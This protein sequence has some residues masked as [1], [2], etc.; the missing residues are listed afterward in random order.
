MTAFDPATIQV[1]ISQCLLGEPVRYDGGH[2]HSTFCTGVL[3][4]YFAFQPVCPEMGAG[5]GTPRESIRLV[6]EAH[7]PRLINSRSQTDV[8]DAIDAYIEVTLPKLSHL[9]GFILMRKSPSCGM[10]RVKVYTTQG[11]PQAQTGQG[12]FAQALMQAYPLL[13]IEEEGRLNDPGLRE[14]FINRVLIWHDWRSRQHQG[15]NSRQLV[16]FHTRHKYLLMAHSESVY[17]QL[18]PMVAQA[19]QSEIKS[20][21]D[22]YIQIFMQALAKPANR[23]G[24]TNVLQHIQG[25]ISAQLTPP[26]RQQL[27]DIIM[28]YRSG[29]IPLI[30][31]VTLLQHHMAHQTQAYPALT[32]YLAPHPAEIGLRNAI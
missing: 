18:G 1:G 15:M 3:S 10:E 6:G 14:N 12:R 27:A 26:Q 4:D 22:R 11:H 16:E 7:S 19:G 31:P 29:Q 24:H 32:G 2:K 9:S 25:F 30:V 13:P 5:L 17:R 21:A 20:R 23:Q 8:T 28:Q